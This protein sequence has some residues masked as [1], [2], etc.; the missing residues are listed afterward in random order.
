MRVFNLELED[1]CEDY[2]QLVKYTGGIP[3]SDHGYSL[4]DHHYFAK[5]KWE[6]VCGNTYDMINKSRLKSYFD[7]LGDSMFIIL[8][9]LVQ[10]VFFH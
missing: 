10:L 9:S 7:F 6:P 4:D 1:K 5:G 8:H 3:F 2:G